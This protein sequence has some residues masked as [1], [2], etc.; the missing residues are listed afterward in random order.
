MSENIA[1]NIPVWQVSFVLY[2]N[3]D[4]NG[5]PAQPELE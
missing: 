3:S 5:I 4:R 2:L 1:I